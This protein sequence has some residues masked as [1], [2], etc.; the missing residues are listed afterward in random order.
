MRSEGRRK[1]RLDCMEVRMPER[2]AVNQVRILIA[3]SP[4][5]PGAGQSAQ[6]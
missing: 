6:G 2:V 4:R 5:F 1:R 3:V